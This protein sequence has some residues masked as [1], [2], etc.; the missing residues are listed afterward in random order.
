MPHDGRALLLHGHG[1][2]PGRLAA[3]GA[4][5]ATLTGFEIVTPTAPCDVGGGHAWWP[6]DAGGPADATLDAL[7]V[8]HGDVDL[9]VGYSQ[10]AALA[11]TLG[12]GRRLVTIAGFLC[13]VAPD[14]RH[15]PGVVVVHG[16]HDDVVDPAH[17]RLIERQA[18]R[19]GCTTSVH[20]HDG[21]HELDAAIAVVLAQLA[22]G[23]A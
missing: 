1:D 2:G 22:D 17:A 21:G 10:G 15:R 16:T 8:A 11:L 14:L 23:A 12:L 9:V 19:A 20:H 5:I 18:R 6:D 3:L 4:A 7:R 13:D